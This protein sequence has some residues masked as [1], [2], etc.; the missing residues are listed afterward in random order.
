MKTL[1]ILAPALLLCGSMLSTANAATPS[2]DVPTMVVKFADLDTTHAPGM[3]ELYRRL[4]RAARTVC[5]PLEGELVG[6]RALA[7][8]RYQACREQAIAGAVAQ[9]NRADFS[10]Y[11]AS[12]THQSSGVTT[13]LA[14]R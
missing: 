12:L 8:A 5:A 6:S 4:D 11:V 9:I 7:A 13:R 1:N 14:A 3:Q 2:D 10:D